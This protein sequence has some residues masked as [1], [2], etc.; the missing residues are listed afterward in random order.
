M[1][2]LYRRTASLILAA[3]VLGAAG[4]ASGTAGD[5]DYAIITTNASDI[6]AKIYPAYL[7]K[8]DDR[9]VKGGTGRFGRK[10]A[11]WVEP[12]LRKV[13]IM[14]DLSR[15]TGVLSKPGYTPRD[16]Q[17]GDI[18]I[19]V[20]AGKRYFLGAQLTANRRDQWQPVVWRVEDIR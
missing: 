3:L 16:Q 19:E 5:A 17:P 9:E 14:A 12:G 7:A 13:R 1:G 18:E 8:V 2:T 4:C 20:E 11:V 6:S 10:E 15:A